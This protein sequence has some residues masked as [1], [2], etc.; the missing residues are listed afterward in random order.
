[1]GFLTSLVSAAIKTAVTPL[2]V[3]VDIVDVVNG[4]VPESTVGLLSEVVEDTIDA[5]SD[6]I[7]GDIV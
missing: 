1:M 7:E 4:E 6:L 2:A 3:V 5:G